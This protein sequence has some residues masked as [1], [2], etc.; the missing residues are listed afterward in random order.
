M[1]LRLLLITR[2]LLILD[3]SPYICFIF[4]IVQS[5]IPT[6]FVR[7]GIA[8]VLVLIAKF[9]SPWLKILSLLFMTVPTQLIFS[10]IPRYLYV[11]L[12][13]IGLM[14]RLLI[15]T[16]YYMFLINFP[17]STCWYAHLSS[18][19]VIPVSLENVVTRSNCF[20]VMLMFLTYNFRSSTKKLC[21]ISLVLSI[22][23]EYPLMFLIIK[24]NGLTVNMN[25]K[26]DW[27]SP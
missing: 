3:P 24:Y 11:S 17:F 12:S 15:F 20:F 4:S 9:S 7:T 6:V 23:Y 27:L 22:P 21:V 19:N 14:L 26:T 25:N 16:S 8:N 10:S 1:L 2:L 13:L 5:I 18:P